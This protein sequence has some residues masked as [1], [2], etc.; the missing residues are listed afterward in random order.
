MNNIY[1]PETI[2]RA[3]KLGAALIV[4]ISGGKDS[5]A[6]LMALIIEYVKHGWTG[7]IYALHCDLGRA[8]WPE[9]LPMCQKM[10]TIA[11]V[12][13]QVVRRPQGDLVQEIEDRMHKLNGTGR[14]FW[15]SSSARY[16]TSDHKRDQ[17]NKELRQ[18]KP[19]WPSAAARYC[20]SHHKTNQA[21]KEFRNFP[22]VIS[23]EG[24]RAE[25]SDFRAKK[26]PVSL[27]KQITGSYYK[28]SRTV[29][30]ALDHCR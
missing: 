29:E 22:L 23:A 5:Q 16:C 3:L 6:M 24:I 19:F 28:R 30:E 12:N 20:T 18:A 1:L 8:E 7:P 4:S 25:E 10:A 15:P 27:R 2:S 9:S 13:L 17:A 26:Q 11:G 21:D 14:P